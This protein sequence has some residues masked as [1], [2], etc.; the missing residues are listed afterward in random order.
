MEKKQTEVAKQF[1]EIYNLHNDPEEKEKRKI[2][3]YRQLRVELKKKELG[4][5]AI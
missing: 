5:N 3:K 1:H 4:V 2:I